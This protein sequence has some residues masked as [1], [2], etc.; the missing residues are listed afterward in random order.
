MWGKVKPTSDNWMY[1]KPVFD[2]SGWQIRCMDSGNTHSVC[3]ADDSVI[4]FGTAQYGELG[5]GPSGPKSSANPKKIDIL[6]G[7]HAISV[8]CGIGHSLI[9]VDRTNMGDQI[10]KLDVYDGRSP[11]EAAVEIVEDIPNKKQSA[12]KSEIE[13]GPQTHKK[14]QKTA[15]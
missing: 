9:V 5:F 7:M 4:G 13:T 2:L 11:I 12:I 3:G 8:A 15:C 10:E 14:L 1:P 6:E